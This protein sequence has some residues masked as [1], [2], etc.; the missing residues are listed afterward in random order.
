MRT[1]RP[2]PSLVIFI[3]L[4]VSSVAQQGVISGKVLEQSSN[5]GLGFA[6]VAVYK[7][8]DT[9][10][11]SYRLSTHTG[12]FR[13]PGL[14]LNIRLRLVITHTGFDA[15]RQEFELNTAKT[16]IIA[17]T[18]RMI[19]TSKDLDEVV[20]IAELPPIVFKKDTI[21]FNAT[22][23]RTLPNALVEDLLK[24]LPGVEVDRDGNISFEGRSV[25]RILVDGK[26]FF[27]D[28][29]KM[30]SRNLPANVIDKVQV[31]DDK[32]EMMRMG[33]DNPN[34]I[35]KVIN[36][37]FK[38]GV[39]KGWFGR[40]YAGGGNKDLYNVGG[41]GNIYR[42]TLQ[43]SIL[44][45][46]NN[47]NKA[48]FSFSE[49]LSVGGFQRNRSNSATQRTNV[50]RTNALGTGISLDNV[51]FGG[52][53]GLGG[54]SISKGTGFNL[55]HAPNLK[56]SFYFQY[57]YNRLDIREREIN[58]I[59]DQF[60]ND[61]VINTN[62][63][64]TGPFYGNRHNLAAGL[65]LKP[66]SVTNIL[67]NAAFMDAGGE[68]NRLTSIVS[69]NNFIGPLSNGNVDLLNQN[70]INTYRHNVSI[71]RLSRIKKGRRFTIGHDLEYRNTENDNFSTSQNHFIYPALIDTTIQQL[72][73]ERLPATD[74][75]AY[76]NYSEPLTKKVTLRISA[77]YEYHKYKNDIS[78]YNYNDNSKSYDEFNAL[79]TN[80]L[81]RR[82]N[83]AIANAGIE[84]RLKNLT[85]TPGIKLQ[86]QKI[87]NDITNIPVPLKQQ[88]TDLLPTLGL[89]YKTWNF[90]YDR[91]VILP[92]YN[93][94]IAVADNSNPYY[95]TLGNPDLVPS[96]RDQFYINYRKNNPKKLLNYG[97][98][99]Q[100]GITKNDVI[101]MITVDDN[102][103]LTNKPVNQ[104]GSH[105]G[106]A[107]FFINKQFKRNTKFNWSFNSNAFVSNSRSRLLYN[108]TATWQN[109]NSVGGRV[110]FSLNAKDKFEWSSLYTIT[111]L[112]NRYKVNAFR[113]VNQVYHTFENEWIL[114]IPKH[115][116]WEA[117][118]QYYIDPVTP[119]AFTTTPQIWNVAV[120]YTMLKNERGILKFEIADLLNT[121]KQVN[122]DVIRNSISTRT[123]NV[124]GRYFLLSFTYNIQTIGDKKKVGGWRLSLF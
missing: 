40:I 39:K 54:I 120:N 43:L 93:Y 3:L 57:F 109:T 6:T 118:M 52:A 77:R 44:A 28:D 76:F 26:S 50:W 121:Y 89:V 104:N 2:F 17:D 19:T 45:Y 73:F 62:S 33:D 10:L 87:I 122:R 20:V 36:L 80:N 78:T 65:R 67:I 101:A 112:F 12:E 124:I 47:I 14:P 64:Q 79:L 86:W 84:Y 46:S 8:S 1:I 98:S 71:T 37:T 113:N 72:R 16:S 75:D 111:Y 60:K 97:F 105:N 55:N 59:V 56:R 15:F 29:P 58:S 74:L 70:H 49:L 91:N 61:T 92:S 38:K 22:A 21:E 4:S 24:K 95:I 35:G 34:N 102:G 31:T 81:N 108:H 66:D 106:G 116:I 63:R 83:Q 9:S 68:D 117:N 115:F 69:T 11:I 119:G 41:I 53:Q 51:N 96:V 23:F 90:Y 32:E 94:L 82:N 99:S 114:R 110:G 48:P 85:I 107:N 42:D 13:V 25:N 30:A 7:S 123:N 88:R 103:V 18:I 5:K 27:G 100:F